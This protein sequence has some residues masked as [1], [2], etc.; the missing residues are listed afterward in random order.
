MSAEIPN[1]KSFHKGHNIYREGQPGSVA[2]LIKKGSVRT[3]RT[4]NNRQIPLSVYRQGQIFGEMGVLAGARRTT[5]AEALEYCELM[6]LTEQFVKN[7]L[8]RCPKT[9]QFLVKLLIERAQ[10]D[11]PSRE[12]EHRGLFPGLCRLLELCHRNHFSCPPQRKDPDWEK[13]L[14]VAEFSR[15]VKDIL[16][17]SQ[18][19]IDRTLDQLAS[20]K[21]VELATVKSG[22]AFSERFV[23]IVDADN[24]FEV[25]SNFHR[26][27]TGTD[28]AALPEMEY[29]DIFDF[30]EAVGASPEVLYAKMAN[31]EIPESLF[32]LARKYAL[33][34]AGEQE[35]GFFEKVRR[36]RKNVDELDGVNDIV[37]VDNKTLKD[38]FAR[39][40]YYKL[41]I[42]LSLADEDAREKIT[43]NLARKIAAVVEED[44]ANRGPV[45]ETEAEDVQEELVDLIKA[46]KKG[47]A[48]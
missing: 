26:E 28:P 25:A 8:T 22:K 34:W 14:R 39:L 10:E 18:I 6:V 13:G 33:A 17:V 32:F 42:L 27:L 48:A 40:G 37:F 23:K 5:S 30:S 29:V 15:Y 19:D 21:L 44:A 3:Y 11:G 9:I 24:F 20:I 4:T 1:M 12:G 43:G 38:V 41:G 36:R 7:L 35:K 16:L 2:F 47:T 46:A 31:R 45:D